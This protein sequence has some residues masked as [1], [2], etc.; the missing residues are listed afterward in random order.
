MYNDW[1]PV[2]RGEGRMIRAAIVGIGRWGRTLIGGVQGK[3][4]AI[5]FTAGDVVRR[6]LV[7]RIVEAYDKAR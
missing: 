7:A 5:R 1:E 3:S 2:N 6:D 4:E